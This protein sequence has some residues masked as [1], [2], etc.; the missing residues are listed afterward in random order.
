MRTGRGCGF[1]LLELL[2]ALAIVATLAALAQPAYRRLMLR[3]HRTEAA[4]AL[5]QVA[6]MQERHQ[7]QHQTYTSALEAAPPAGLGLKAMS[8]EGRYTLAITA[9]DANGFVAVATA[10][11]GQADDV[12]CASFTLDESGTKSSSGPGCWPR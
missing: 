5:M 4:S 3:V 7:L 12:S 2:V 8:A 6:A 11:G 1:S 10:R 9:A